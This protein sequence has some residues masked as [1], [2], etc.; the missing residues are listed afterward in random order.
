MS[1]FG[2]TRPTSAKYAETSKTLKFLSMN[3]A[4]YAGTS[5]TP[6]PLVAFI[7]F[8]AG[9]GAGVPSKNIIPHTMNLTGYAGTFVLQSYE[10]LQAKA[11]LFIL[12][13]IFPKENLHASVLW[14]QAGV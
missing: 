2:K 10:W 7:Y 13:R 3:L 14:F 8:D 9:K 4:G 1:G 12:W 6:P 11:H 5:G